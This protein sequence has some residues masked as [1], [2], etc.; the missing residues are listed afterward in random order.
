[1]ALIPF[2]GASGS[3]MLNT[4]D[5]NLAAEAGTGVGKWG[6]LRLWLGIP[7]RKCFPCSRLCEM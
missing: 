7:G 4:K 1:M 3:E 6:N 5:V 2:E